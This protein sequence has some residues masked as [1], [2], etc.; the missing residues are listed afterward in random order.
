MYK[1]K[2]CTIIPPADYL[3]SYDAAIEENPGNSPIT[4]SSGRKKRAVAEHTKFWKPGRTLKVRFLDPLSPYELF[5]FMQVFAQ[6]EQ[7]INLHFELALTG[8]AEIRIRTKTDED[9]SALGTDAL[10]I[11]KSEPTMSISL[12][13]DEEYFEANLLHE[14]GHAIGLLHEHTHLEANIPWNKQKVYE[15]YGKMGWTQA[16]VDKNI[17]TPA[18]GALV[19]TE[20]DKASIMHYPV[21][22]ELTDGVWEVGIN[23]RLSERDKY[24]ASKIYPA[25]PDDTPWNTQ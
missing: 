13:P 5:M 15:Y 22:N 9:R 4:E 10:T 7:H 24:A 2:P 6:W 12:R 23:T 16:E 8:E 11:D 20:Y 14:I 21:P 1:T 3:T 18:N 25:A 17:L 19:D